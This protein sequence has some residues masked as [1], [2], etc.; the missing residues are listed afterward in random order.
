[1]DFLIWLLL[2][3]TLALGGCLVVLLFVLLVRWRRTLKPRPLLIGLA[4]SVVLLLL[5]ALVVTRREHADRIMR[6]I[7]LDLVASR[8]DAITA[9]LSERFYVSET[10]WDRDRFLDRVRQYLEAVDVRTLTRRKL[11]VET[12]EAGRFQ[13]YVSYLAD[14]STRELD[15]PVLSRW[16]IE[17]VDE[18]G[19][20]R[21]LT[22]QPTSIE[23]RPIGGWKGLPKP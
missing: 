14:I 20:W 2:E 6:A 17:F 7:E 16:Q 1:M 5:Q 19:Q 10:G 8:P 23:R 4:L 13:I 9:A 21:I 12:S 15:S 18:A 11:A 3:S 22:I